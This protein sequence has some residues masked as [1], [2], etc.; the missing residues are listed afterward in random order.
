VDLTRQNPAA[1]G[2]VSGWEVLA[3]KTLSDHLYIVMD[4]TVGSAGGDRSFELCGPE[5]SSARRRNF[6]RWAT[7]HRDEDLMTTAAMAV[8]WA[9]EPPAHEET[10]AGAARLRRDLHAICNSCM[11][12]SGASRC[13]GAVYWW[14][15]EIAHLREACIRARRRYTRSRRRRREDESTMAYLYDAYRK[16]RMW[17]PSTP[18]PGD[19][20]TD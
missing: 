1:S 11:P 8:A 10:E 19:A 12:R 4:V 2:R 14:S 9:E 18:I 5:G 13:A 15:E 16:A 7:T 20:R 6:P 3:E 17:P